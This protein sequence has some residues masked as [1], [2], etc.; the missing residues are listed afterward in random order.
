M[1]EVKKKKNAKLLK[2]N[3]LCLPSQSRRHEQVL[4]EWIPQDGAT[5]GQ[6]VDG[7]LGY[8]ADMMTVEHCR[9]FQ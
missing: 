8:D 2:K 4:N 7:M 5:R 3:S 6:H 9:G 1:G